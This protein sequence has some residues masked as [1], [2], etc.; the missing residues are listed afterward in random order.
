MNLA[1]L[2][3]KI[4][5]FLKKN[6]K[7]VTVIF[8]IWLAIFLLN[9]ILKHEAKDY[10][11]KTTLKTH[12]SVINSESSVPSTVS[13]TIEDLIEEYVGYCNEGNYQ[14]AFNMISDDCK[15]YAFNNDIVSFAKHVLTKM[16]EP[17][18]YALQD[19][20]NVNLGGETVYIYEVKYTEDILATGLTNQEYLYTSERFTFYYDDNGL[21]MNVGEYIFHETPKRISENEYLKIDVTDRYV[22]Y[23]I[24]TYKVKITNKSNYTIVIS[25]GEELDEIVLNL[26]NEVRTRSEVDNIVL[27]PMQDG[28]YEMTFKKF[29]DDG[30]TPS[31]LTL[32]QVRVM[33]KYSGTEDDDVDEET[34][35]SE[36][37][38][39]IA[40]FS[41][42]VNL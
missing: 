32:A 3:V 28:E 30:D 23:S 29:V 24:E 18:R 13:S 37:D 40:K 14:K 12:T 2:R 6:G 35:K 39:A 16:P 25:D 8:L 27:G 15:E 7:L 26:P 17:R 38:N 41:M 36:Q 9:Y 31:G 34:V 33:E 42:S 4:R 5:H 22:N 19:Y 21:E 1:D 11:P 10:T 20:S